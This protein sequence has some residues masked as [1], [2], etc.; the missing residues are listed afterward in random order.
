MDKKAKELLDTFNKNENVNSD[1]QIELNLNQSKLKKVDQVVIKND[2]NNNKNANINDVK[3][4]KWLK[5]KCRIIKNLIVIGFA[6]MFLFTV[7]SFIFEKIIIRLS[8]F[9]LKILSRIW[10]SIFLY[11]ISFDTYKFRSTPLFVPG[12]DHF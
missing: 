8:F 5:S 9:L 4:N 10:S 12:L 6:W 3:K 1:H 11:L 7:S 2:E